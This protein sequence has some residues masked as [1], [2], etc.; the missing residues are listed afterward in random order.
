M[1]YS[2]I[3]PVHNEADTVEPLYG[4]L[5]KTMRKLGGAYEIIFVDDGSTD[6]SAENVKRLGTD[7]GNLVL[8]ALQKRYGLSTALQAGFDIAKGD[9]VVTLDGDLQNDPEDIP[10]LLSKIKEGFDVVCG[11]RS[12]RR[13]NLSKRAASGLANSFRRH[14]LGEK[15]HDVG[16]TLRIMKNKAARSLRLSGNLHRFIS[17]LLAKQGFK[18]AEVKVTHHARRFGRSKFG[19]FHRA[20]E[21]IQDFFKI[22]FSRSGREA[23]QKTGYE[24]KETL[25]K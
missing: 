19:I 23:F 7:G 21:G 13:D 8:L 11:W 20:F 24:I 25:R 9:V 16:C 5:Q 14:C 2:V 15:I 17:Y 4:T 3:I 12:P 6:G 18:I 1:D 10:K 22:I